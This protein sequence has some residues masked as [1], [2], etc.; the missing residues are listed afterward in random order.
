VVEDDD[1]R[2]WFAAAD[3][4]ATGIVELA[5]IDAFVDVAGWRVGFDCETP[6]L[7]AAYARAILDENVE[8]RSLATKPG[9]PAGQIALPCRPDATD[10]EITHV[11]LSVM[12]ASHALEFEVVMELDAARASD[13]GVTAS[14]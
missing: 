14:R 3:R 7:T 6:E 8:P 5:H 10:E 11:V 9:R 4:I 1:R 13:Q 12:K 2:R